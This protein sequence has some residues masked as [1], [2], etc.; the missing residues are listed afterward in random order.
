VSVN[1]QPDL[2][3]KTLRAIVTENDK[4]IQGLKTQKDSAVG[5]LNSELELVTRP[6]DNVNT[7]SETC[8][9]MPDNNT[10]SAQLTIA[11]DEIPRSENDLVEEQKCVR[12]YEYKSEEHSD[13]E[14]AKEDMVRIF[15]IF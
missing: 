1:T 15:T 6:R 2:D 7:A 8:A 5:A 4:K 10:K 12:E 3:Q 13:K 11:R 14:E 9:N